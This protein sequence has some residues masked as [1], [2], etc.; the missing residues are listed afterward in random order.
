[1][2][3]KRQNTLAR[4][5]YKRLVAEK[6]AKQ[7]QRAFL[8]ETAA[9]ER[10]HTSRKQAS[11]KSSKGKETPEMREKTT[12]KRKRRRRERDEAGLTSEKRPR[13]SHQDEPR[14]A[15]R[16]P[17]APTPGDCLA[18]TPRREQL[19]PVCKESRD[20]VGAEALTGFEKGDACCTSGSRAGMDTGDETNTPMQEQRSIHEVALLESD[21]QTYYMYVPVT[22]R[23]SCSVNATSPMDATLVAVPMMPTTA[24]QRD[25]ARTQSQTLQ[26][27]DSSQLNGVVDA[28]SRKAARGTSQVSI[29]STAE[30]SVERS[31]RD[32]IL[33]EPQGQITDAERYL[34]LQRIL[35]DDCFMRKCVAMW[36][37]QFC[38]I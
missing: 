37:D 8:D 19:S 31:S 2:H 38:E 4:G 26:A 28:A 33:P 24:A 29:S 12:S 36:R 35:K 5:R 16:R 7:D 21:P 20:R 15:S 32:Q 6:K 22:L 9:P 18:K 3:R 25:Q 10:V 14:Q 1:M 11:G 30:R 13:P 23:Q 27:N 34:T 17:K